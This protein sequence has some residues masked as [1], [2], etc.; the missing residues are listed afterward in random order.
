MRIWADIYD[1]AGNRLGAGP[2]QNLTRIS[3]TRALDG[4]GSIRASAILTDERA[5]ALLQNERR[6]RLYVEHN[7]ITRELGRG[8]IRQIRRNISEGGFSLEVDG[9][10]DL[11]ELTR[12][13]T[14]LGRSYSGLSVAG[15]AA[16][17]AGIA[18]WSTLPTGA[19]NIISARFDGASVFKALRE[20][21]E[22][23]GLHIRRADLD[24]HIEIGPFGDSS[25]VRIQNAQS[26]E[27]ETQFNDE[28]ML[29]DRLRIDQT[30]EAVANWIVPLGQ[31]EG[32]AAL[33]LAKTTRSSP[34]TVGQMIGPN[35]KTLYYLADQ[36]SIDLYGRIERV[37]T[38]KQIGAVSNSDADLVLAANALYD[39]AAAWLQRNSVRLDTYTCTARKPRKTIRPGQK[40]RL[41][42]RGEILSEG[43]PYTY[44]DINAEFWVMEVTE[45]VGESGHTI[46]LKLA[47]ID[48]EQQT[49]AQIVVGALESITIRNLR[50]Q[51]YPNIRS[52]V[53]RREVDASHTATVPAL[54]TETTTA[55]NRAIL[56]FSMRPFR[57]TA[58]GAASGGGQAIT[59]QAGGQTITSTS[60]GG[61]Q[62]ATS[63]GS[64]SHSHRVF[65]YTAS[66]I[67]PTAARNYVGRLS[68]LVTVSP[69]IL[70][71]S[72]AADIYTYDSANDHTHSVTI[73]LHTHGFVVPNHQHDI[74]LP[75][76]THPQ[77]YAIH[78]DNQSPDAVEIE[79]NGVNVTT[80]LG[81]PWSGSE[82]I[83]LD[84]TEY[85]VNASGGLRQKHEIKFV[86]KA[87]QGEIEV[88]VELYETIQALALA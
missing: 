71:T 7:N 20:L 6:I 25:G 81:G 30:S 10:D 33:T 64:G 11:D 41:V 38:F 4:I 14:L 19:D 39:A 46:D 59:S 69:L 82:E 22:H 67:P 37:V 5:A 28:I 29:I 66:A 61:G 35:G 76:H 52:F 34:Y 75:N 56:S 53:Y 44:Q 51:T 43:R 1:S 8:V 18:G 42:Y 72:Q 85:L 60:A 40:I 17:L 84:I 73:P 78:D 12:Y 70:A 62:V 27:I 58:S 63:A 24:K 3:V 65:A 16:A 48:R 80:A 50:I 55:L 36:A 49:A 88:T 83:R 74:T 2:V 9:P 68:D 79:I 32:E 31:G 23:Q 87:G 86:P 13:N 45:S 15:V 57:S 26:A 21:A 77:L 47:S 54:L